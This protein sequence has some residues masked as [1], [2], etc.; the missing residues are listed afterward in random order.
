MKRTYF[1]WNHYKIEILLQSSP[2]THTNISG[3]ISLSTPNFKNYNYWFFDNL[4]FIFY[5]ISSKTQPLG[6][7]KSF[8]EI[9]SFRLIEFTKT[10]G[11][12]VSKLCLQYT[13]L[14]SKYNTKL[15]SFLISRLRSF[16][17]PP[18][19][20]LTILVWY[21]TLRNIIFLKF[22]KS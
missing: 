14:L 16:Q 9:N 12:Y 18:I 8:P 22:V 20:F 1:Y 6:L 17:W 3:H 11:G 21:P 7:R 10:T 2:W 19:I 13:L 4:T 5:S 15:I